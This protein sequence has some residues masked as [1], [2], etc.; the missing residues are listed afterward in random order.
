MENTLKLT[1]ILLKKRERELMDLSTNIP[2]VK[3]VQKNSVQFQ[4]YRKIRN[5]IRKIK[6]F[7]NAGGI[8]IDLLND[9]IAAVD[10]SDLH[11]VYKT[12]QALE[13]QWS[14]ER[15]KP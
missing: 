8:D 12:S 3:A 11:E 7:I 13:K 6:S 14:R 5:E 9:F 4:H 10:K 1:Q 15:Y 2:W